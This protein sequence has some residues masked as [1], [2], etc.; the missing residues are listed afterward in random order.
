MTG[1]PEPRIVVH[2]ERLVVRDAAVDP[3]SADALRE[4]LV[5]ELGRLLAGRH[6]WRPGT[7]PALRTSMA[8][9][10]AGATEGRRADPNAY[11]RAL[12]QAVHGQLPPAAWRPPSSA[13]PGGGR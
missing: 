3:R 1:R 9:A 7:A 13:R 10:T 11:G 2:I 12:A 4:A 6:G 5:H 8:P